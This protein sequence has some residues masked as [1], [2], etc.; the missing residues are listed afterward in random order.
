MP[1]PIDIL[2]GVTDT[3]NAAALAAQSNDPS[4]SNV[5]QELK[6]RG[7]VHV[8]TDEAELERTLSEDTVTYYCGFDP[9]ASSATSATLR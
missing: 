3:Q 1:P 6:R 7:Y 5:F 9:T 4:F 8:S 2:E